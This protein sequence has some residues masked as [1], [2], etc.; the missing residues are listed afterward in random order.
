MC[1]P[2]AP[3]CCFERTE[4]SVGLRGGPD[5]K[6][7][8]ATEGAKEPRNAGPPIYA[9]AY[10]TLENRLRPG[11][12][13]AACRGD[14]KRPAAVRFNQTIACVCIKLLSQ[15]NGASYPQ[16]QT[17]TLSNS[18]AVPRRSEAPIFLGGQRAWK[19]SLF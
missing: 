14:G 3:S 18:S 10:I 1:R 7:R 19:L 9:Y 2:M 17:G 8:P 12:S 15:A 13:G 16:S 5:V 4:T 6:T 11:S